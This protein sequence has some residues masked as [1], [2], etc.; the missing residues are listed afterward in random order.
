MNM[1]EIGC[2]CPSL[3]TNSQSV[4]VSVSVSG[5]YCC[6]VVAFV[7]ARWLRVVAGGCGVRALNPARRASLAQ[8]VR[9]AM[10]RNQNS[11]ELPAA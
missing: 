5:V 10:N 6:L 9:I 11:N 3:L 2:Y 8:F 7:V 4:S 1:N